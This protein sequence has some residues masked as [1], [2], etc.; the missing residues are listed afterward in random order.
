M[1]STFEIFT[2]FKAGLTV[3]VAAP[4]FHPF[5]YFL[6]NQNFTEAAPQTEVD[7]VLCAISNYQHCFEKQ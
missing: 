1:H 5:V 7:L 3:T 2:W 6:E 4:K